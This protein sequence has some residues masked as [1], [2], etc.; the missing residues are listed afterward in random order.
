[1]SRPRRGALLGLVTLE[2][3]LAAALAYLFGL[4]F[5]ATRY[6]DLHEPSPPRCNFVV[7]VPAHNEER[8]I[9]H[10]LAAL[11]QLDFPKELHEVVVIAD[12]CD[13]RTAELAEDAGATVI[14]RLSDLRG[15]GH[16]LAWAIDWTFSNRP[17]IDAIVVV[18]AD[19]EP[20]PNLLTVVEER[21]A[22]GAEAVQ[23]NYVVANPEA[24]TGSAL[25]YAAFALKNTVR[26][27]GKAVLGLSSGLFGTGMGFSRSC[28][29]RHPWEAF[30]LVEDAEY[31]LKLVLEGSR[32][33]FAPEAAVSSPMP[34]TT[35]ARASQETRWASGELRLIRDWVPRLLSR[36]V[37]ERSPTLANAAIEQL[38]PPQSPLMVANLLTLVGAA[39]LR[40]RKA[41]LLAVAN[42]ASQLLLVTGVLHLVRAPAA[43]Y[44]ALLAA[45]GLLARKVLMYL[46]LPLGG[47]PRE[48]ERTARSP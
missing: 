35:G 4:A 27:Q 26:P 37:R 23:V 16:A 2:A 21:L 43:V 24:S 32:V 41:F 11:G 36:A 39:A 42:I 15:K 1:M 18:D 19:C 20:T 29:E 33:E 34:T 17:G 5:A 13:D 28:L 38:V 44:R 14:E 8:V 45:P 6:R 10:T 47:H 46:R 7:L 22:H 30:S 31:H 25:R 40:S 9:A 12:N 48:W 3:G